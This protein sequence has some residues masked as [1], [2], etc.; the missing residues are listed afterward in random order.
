M[1]KTHSSLIHLRPVS[2]PNIYILSFIITELCPVLFP[3]LFPEGSKRYHRSFAKYR[4]GKMV[5]MVTYMY[6]GTTYH[7]LAAQSNHQTES[8]SVDMRYMYDLVVLMDETVLAMHCANTT[9]LT[10]KLVGI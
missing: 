4:S 2:P 3:G 6:L 10:R 9:N 5:P 7:Q 8:Y 1:S